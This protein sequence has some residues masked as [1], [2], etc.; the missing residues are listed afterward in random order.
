MSILKA[1]IEQS[2]E[3]KK[4]FSIQILNLKFRGKSI[5]ILYNIMEIVVLIYSILPQLQYCSLGS[6]DES[7]MVTILDTHIK[8]LKMIE[9]KVNHAKTEVIVF[10]KEQNKVLINVKGSPVELKDCIKALGIQI[11]K[12]L[13][14][15]T[16][17]SNL[18]RRISYIIG[19]RA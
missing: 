6:G 4:A 11:D 5:M 17:I 8:N 19:S 14:W 15:K 1:L 7:S 2:M 18:K 9:I 10:G 16:H 13:S 12:D 3:D